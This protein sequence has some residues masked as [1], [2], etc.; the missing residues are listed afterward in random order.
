M[1]IQSAHLPLKRLRLS[2]DDIQDAASSVDIAD[3][4][5]DLALRS[6]QEE[7][8]KNAGRALLRWDGHARTRPGK[9]AGAVDRQRQR[10]EAGVAAQVLRDVLIQRNRVAERTT[11]RM[12]SS[13]QEADV[14]GM[15]A[16][17]IRMRYTAEYGEV[18]A[19]LLQERQ[20]VRRGVVEPAP[21]GKKCSG[22]TPRLLQIANMRRGTE[23][24]SFGAA[25]ANA[26]VA[27][28]IDD[29]VRLVRMVLALKVRGQGRADTSR[30]HFRQFIR[31]PRVY[32]ATE[33]NAPN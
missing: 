9:A 25:R 4:L 30:C 6:L 24:R 3:P 12:W 29:I 7:L 20:I 1:T 17:D 33:A 8:L 13:G 19:E 5:L 28:L 26:G 21:A 14:R 11:R 15:P 2:G 22:S 31:K 18:L 16:V 10:R 32:S 27:P 23:R